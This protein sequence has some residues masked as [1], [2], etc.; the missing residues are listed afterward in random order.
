MLLLLWLHERSAEQTFTKDLSGWP[1]GAV[2]CDRVHVGG[3]CGKLHEATQQEDDRPCNSFR[4]QDCLNTQLCRF[5]KTW[6]TVSGWSWSSSI[7]CI[8]HDT[9]PKPPYWWLVLVRSWHATN[10]EMLFDINLDISVP[11]VLIVKVARIAN[12]VPCHPL[13]LRVTMNVKIFA[14]NQKCNHCP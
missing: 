9:C 10:M 8:V 4:I 6:K 12:A 14:H 13:Y 3:E 5:L 2:G 11:F 7:M 1:A